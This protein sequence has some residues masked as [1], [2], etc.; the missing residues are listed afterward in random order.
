MKKIEVSG[1]VALERWYEIGMFIIIGVMLLA[2]S[3][4]ESAWKPISGLAMAVLFIYFIIAIAV[5]LFPMIVMFDEQWLM[6]K[7][8]MF[9]KDIRMDEITRVRYYIM[10]RKRGRSSTRFYHLVMEIEYQGGR[11]ELMEC[12]E[13]AEIEYCKNGEADKELFVLYDHI[14]ELYPDK[15]KGYWDYCGI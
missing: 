12:I 6:M 14:K 8:G 9:R 2:V 4:F 10:L 7:H 13:K 5:S 3:L 1:A 11:Q 15:A